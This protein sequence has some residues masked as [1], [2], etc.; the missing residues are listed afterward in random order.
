MK[1]GEIVLVLIGLQ[2]SE[3]TDSRLIVEEN[4][5]AKIAVEELG[6]SAQRKEVKI[7]ADLGQADLGKGFLQCQMRI[8][9]TGTSS[10]SMLTTPFPVL[11]DS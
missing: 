5:A 4:E 2:V 3:E 9:S 1:I 10:T 7:G 11:S 6:S 8:S